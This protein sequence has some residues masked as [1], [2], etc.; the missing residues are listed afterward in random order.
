[1][2][3]LNLSPEIEKKWIN[4]HEY[5]HQHETLKEV[6]ITHMQSHHTGKKEDYSYNISFCQG[7]IRVDYYLHGT[8]T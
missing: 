2:F 3:F 6:V 8:L 7:R 4:G 5:W 1:M